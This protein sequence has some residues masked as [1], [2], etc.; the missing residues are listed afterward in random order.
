[1]SEQVIVKVGIDLNDSSKTRAIVRKTVI[2]D[3][4]PRQGR[5]YGLN[6]TGVWVH[7]SEGERYPDECFLPV[8]FVDAD[9]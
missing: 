4:P 9:A 2:E 7:V 5:R 8:V 3:G 6:V 1:M